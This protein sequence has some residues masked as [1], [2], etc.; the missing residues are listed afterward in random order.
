MINY[1][2]LVSRQGKIRLAKWFVTLLPSAKAKIIRDVI[3]LVLGRRQ[4]MCN[5]LEYKGKKVLKHAI[6]P[7]DTVRFVNRRIYQIVYRRYA[8]LFLI[9]EIEEGDNELLTLETIHRYVEVLDLYFGNVIF[10]KTHPSEN[11]TQHIVAPVSIPVASIFNFEKAYL[12]LDQLIA[13]GELLEPS[14]E[15]V[16]SMVRQ[17]TTYEKDQE[18]SLALAE[19]TV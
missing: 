6:S 1:F 8:S 14:K 4:R 9:C 16:L 12:I 3:N 2:L 15:E 10:C 19:Y 13:G 5:F 11:N 18:V 17:Y 7:R